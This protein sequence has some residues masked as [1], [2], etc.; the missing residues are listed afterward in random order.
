[1]KVS[2]LRIKNF[3]SIRELCI[4][5]MDNACILVGKNNTGKT[6]V[7]EAIRAVTGD[8]QISS[9][10]FNDKG[11]CIEI[12][13]CLQITQGDLDILYRNGMVSKY[14]NYQVWEKDFREKLPSYQEGELSFTYVVHPDGQCFYEDGVKKNNFRIQ[15]VL[16]KIYYIDHTRNVAEMEKDFLSVQ[17]AEEQ[18]NMS[19][20]TCMFDSSKHCQHCF[21]CIGMIHKKRRKH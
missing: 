18:K 16:P 5:E 17:T 14:R 6:V 19:S 9:R 15:E 20:V 1:M 10:D 12:E 3:K 8:Y 2:H 21:Q 13:I 11:R 4:K 7:L